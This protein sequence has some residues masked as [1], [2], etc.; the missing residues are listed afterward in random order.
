[1]F[2]DMHIDPLD[3]RGLVFAWKIRAHRPCE[4][5]RKEF[6]DGLVDL[7]VDSL[8]K[9]SKVIEGIE[10][11]IQS[12]ND[13]KSF[14]AFA[15]D[16]NREP[17]QKSLSIE[18]AASLWQLILNGRF[19]LLDDWLQ[20]ISTKSHSIPKDTYLLLLEFADSI[21]P[22]LSNFDDAGMIGYAEVLQ[23]GLTH[24]VG[25]RSGAWPVLIDEFVD[26]MRHRSVPP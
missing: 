14:Y 26:H 2:T 21:A 3:I 17:D 20:F 8:P 1:M 15:Y 5:S 10:K 13:F 25:L 12:S 6:V 23:Q 9:L 19:P 16:Y 18:T 24:S 4:F 11:Y 7:G 22:D